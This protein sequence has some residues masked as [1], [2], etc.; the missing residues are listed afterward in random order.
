VSSRRLVVGIA[1]AVVVCS[2]A[3]AAAVS[4]TPAARESS[5]PVLEAIARVVKIGA[6]SEADASA[7][8]ATYAAALAEVGRLQGLRRQELQSAISITQGIAARG[9]LIASRM[10]L[11]FLTLRRNVEWWSAHGPPAPGA[12][13]EPAAQGRRCKPLASADTQAPGPEAQ[14]ANLT[15]PDSKVEYEYYPGMGLQLQVN[16]TFGTIDALLT[17]GSR[18]SL[19]QAE[20]TLDQML[21]LVSY[22]AGR[23][24]W[25][26]EFPFEGAQPPWT[27]GLSQATAIEAFTRAATKLKR[28]DYLQ[29]AL[30]LAQLFATPPP[31]GVQVNLDGDW[32]LLYSFDPGQ[33]VLNADLDSL[34]ALHDLAAA[35]HAPFVSALERSGLHAL[36]RNIESFDIGSW[37]LYSLGGPLANLNYHALNLELA[38]KLCQRTGIGIICHA[39]QSFEREL[40]A[41]CPL[42]KHSPDLTGA[43]A[44]KGALAPSSAGPDMQ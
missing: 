13:L 16:A 17:K 14:A 32:F 9:S 39:A 6:L 21:K 36:E 33:L 28:P 8:R 3:T 25:E 44:W 42:V 40:N 4:P 10:A 37:S 22:R 2:G 43:V 7:Y 30:R 27:S 20:A 31:I 38:Q 1:L 15:F 26:Y 18:R 19:A 23:M 29:A 24:T 11:V 41:R 12:G 35:T 5:D 34:I